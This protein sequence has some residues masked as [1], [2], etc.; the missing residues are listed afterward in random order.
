MSQVPGTKTARA[1]QISA[2]ELEGDST[3]IGGDPSERLPLRASLDPVGEED[4]RRLTLSG[5]AVLV[6]LLT[7]QVVH[8]AQGLRGKTG[9]LSGFREDEVER[10]AARTV[11]SGLSN[12]LRDVVPQLRDRPIPGRLHV[13]H[14]ELRLDAPRRERVPPVAEP[15]EPEPVSRHH[16]VVAPERLRVREGS[17]TD[18]HPDRDSV[19][20]HDTPPAP[21]ESCEV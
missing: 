3:L 17:R 10:D 16:V 4:R 1:T 11:L 18:P 14:D 12:D 20:S 2:A 13:E 21:S 19:Q 8:R 7:E 15:V 6:D 9:D 5:M